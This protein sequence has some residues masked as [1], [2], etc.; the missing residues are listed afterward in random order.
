LYYNKSGY[1][2]VSEAPRLALL[3]ISPY[4]AFN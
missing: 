4:F 2:F 1:S 3:Q